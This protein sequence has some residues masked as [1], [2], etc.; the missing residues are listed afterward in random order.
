MDGFKDL[1]LFLQ[2]H[3]VEKISVDDHSDSCFLRITPTESLTIHGYVFHDREFSIIDVFQI[4]DL[5]KMTLKT[6]KEYKK[7]FYEDSRIDG[8]W[9]L[10]DR[11]ENFIIRCADENRRVRKARRL[12]E[13]KEIIP[14]NSP[15]FKDAFLSALFTE[16]QIPSFEKIGYNQI[17]DNQTRIEID[18]LLT[19]AKRQFK[20]QLWKA[21]ISYIPEEALY[22][23]IVDLEETHLSKNVVDKIRLYPGMDPAFLNDQRHGDPSMFASPPT[24]S[25]T[26][27]EDEL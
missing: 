3:N 17:K 13:I 6:E 4:A 20:E 14:E 24:A 21:M 5:F 25:Q 18:E 11:T 15:S 1:R 10:S 27:L 8:K 26:T 2:K 12:A 16:K 22:K 23:I 19:D 9:N 7:Y